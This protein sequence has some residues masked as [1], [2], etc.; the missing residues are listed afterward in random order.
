MTE[1]K[2][3]HR[4]RDLQLKVSAKNIKS[5]WHLKE[6]VAEHLGTVGAN[7]QLMVKTTGKTLAAEEK[8]FGPYEKEELIVQLRDK[9]AIRI[10]TALS[11][12]V[13]V[14]LVASFVTSI[15][16]CDETFNYWEPTHYLIYGFGQQTWEYSPAYSLRSYGYISLHAS[17]GWLLGLFGVVDKIC[18]WYAIRASLGVFSAL[19]E[20]LFFVGVRHRFGAKIS[21]LT[22]LFMLTA[23]GTFHAN[24]AFLPSTFSMYG[25]LLG[26]GLWFSGRRKAAV[27]AGAFSVIMGWPFVG[28]LFIPLGLEVLFTHGL[29]TTI[30]W[31]V[32]SIVVFLGPSMLVDFIYYRGWKVAVLNIVL[33]NA[34]SGEDGG[35]QLYGVEPWSFYFLNLFL[36]MNVVWAFAIASLPVCFFSFHFF[37]FFFLFPMINSSYSTILTFCDLKTARTSPQE[38]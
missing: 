10:S 24:V 25:V 30:S 32:Q 1:L 7:V 11:A 29:L 19:C 12:L 13:L 2:L 23:A 20:T 26:Y 34:T 37:F 16:D 27:F 17:I 5:V 35:G 9:E 22:L 6:I 18:V 15:S 4:G 28:L 3:R 38:V 8:D 31:S 14:R 33:Y 21:K 36:N